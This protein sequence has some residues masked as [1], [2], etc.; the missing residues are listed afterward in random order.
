MIPYMIP[1]WNSIGY[2]EIFKIDN[3][4]QATFLI[5]SVIDS[6]MRYPDSQSKSPYYEHLIYALA[7]IL[8]EL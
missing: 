7:Q 6:W 1:N 4:G 5:D 8:A 3:W 2:F